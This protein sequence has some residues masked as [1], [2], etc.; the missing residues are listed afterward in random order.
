MAVAATATVFVTGLAGMTTGLLPATGIVA[1]VVWLAI[2]SS[3]AVTVAGL[4]RD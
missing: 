4:E 1:E 3:G 2:A